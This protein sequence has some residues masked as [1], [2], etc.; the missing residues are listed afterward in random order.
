ML[1]PSLPC[2]PQTGPFPFLRRGSEGSAA[3]SHGQAS[4]GELERP[5][6]LQGEEGLPR[7][8]GPTDPAPDPGPHA[9][10]VFLIEELLHLLAE[11]HLLP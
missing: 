1:T 6:W 9:L 2:A 7:K 11:D 5:G 3:T 10:T 4:C 8:A